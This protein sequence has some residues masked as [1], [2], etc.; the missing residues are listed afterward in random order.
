MRCCILCARSCSM[1]EPVKEDEAPLAAPLCSLRGARAQTGALACNCARNAG[2]AAVRAYCRCGA[3][4]CAGTTRK[5][6]GHQV[7]RSS[8]P[9]VASGSHPED[10]LGPQLRRSGRRRWRL[11][12]A[13]PPA[14]ADRSLTARSDS[15]KKIRQGKRKR[16]CERQT[17]VPSRSRGAAAPLH[18][19]CV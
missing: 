8:S 18:R 14:E 4:P 2:S 7:G 9:F 1:S 19:V 10:Q 11:P 12:K 15:R 3:P 16:A 13:S 6:H 5:I 17:A